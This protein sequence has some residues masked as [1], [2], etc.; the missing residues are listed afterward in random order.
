[1][2]FAGNLAFFQRWKNFTNGLRVD[3]VMVHFLGHAVKQ[4]NNLCA[5]PTAVTNDENGH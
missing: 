5:I 2:N 3:E 4:L 1:M